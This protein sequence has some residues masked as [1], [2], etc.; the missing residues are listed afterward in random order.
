MIKK[1]TFIYFSNSI[2]YFFK[3][4]NLKKFK[5]IYKF[6]FYFF[7]T[8]YCLISKPVFVFKTDKII[9]QLFYFVIT[10]NFFK[11]KILRKNFHYNKLMNKFKQKKIKRKPFKYWINNR[12]RKR[13]F[14]FNKLKLK[15]RIALKK[16]SNISL[17]KLYPNKFNILCNVL[18]KAFNKNIELNLVRL[19]YPYKNSNIFANLLALLINKIKFRR[20]TRKL[21]KFAVIKN[22]KNITATGDNKSNYLPAYLTGMNI[23]IAGRLMNYNIIP[24][25]TVQK[26]QKGSSSFG[27]VNYTDFARYTSKNRRGAFSITVSSG[28]NF[29]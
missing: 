29:F 1:G 25:K 8:M 5:N 22:I 9:I 6:L 12:I 21:F 20:I 13:I 16:A 14:K 7:K 4:N 18:S 17:I 10:P 23:K 24:R 26:I 3:N 11:D 15:I 2:G 27:K 28:Q 19:H